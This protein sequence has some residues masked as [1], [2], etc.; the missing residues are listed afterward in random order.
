MVYL[1]KVAFI[2]PIVEDQGYEYK[3]DL[4]IQGFKSMLLAEWILC[5]CA[6]YTMQF[7]SDANEL[8]YIYRFATGCEWITA[9]YFVCMIS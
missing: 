9:V 2:V 8:F 7:K 6:W 4:P 1:C 5:G 3:A